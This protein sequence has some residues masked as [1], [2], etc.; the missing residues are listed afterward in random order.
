MREISLS[1]PTQLDVVDTL[2][3]ACGQWG[4]LLDGGKIK[5][6][7]FSLGMNDPDGAK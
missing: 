2:A 3:L 6:N 1:E 5:R 4:I 7:Q